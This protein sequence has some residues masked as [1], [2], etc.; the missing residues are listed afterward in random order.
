MRL[1]VLFGYP[2]K[3]QGTYSDFAKPEFRALALVRA[4][5]RSP[6]N[7]ADVYTVAGVSYRI[8][9]SLAGQNA[10]LNLIAQLM[11]EQIR[12]RYQAATILPVPSSDHTE[13]G[14]DFTGLRLARAIQSV[15]ANFA[16]NAAYTWIQTVQKASEGGTRNPTALQP[17]L[18]R[19]GPAP[20]QPIVLIDDVATTCGHLFACARDLRAEGIEVD[21]AYCV[22]KTVWERPD[23]LFSIPTMDFDIDAWP[24][25]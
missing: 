17:L 12:E 8:E 7:G 3:S 6:F 19:H 10:A 21:D 15:D 9:N 1:N 20:Q 5:K 14:C 2:S 11:A 18:V 24:V 23:K 25:D 4:L 13:H 22:A 16:A